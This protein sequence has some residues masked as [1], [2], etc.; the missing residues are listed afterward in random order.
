M[1]LPAAAGNLWAG[2]R[3][4]QGPANSLATATVPPSSVSLTKRPY[5]SLSSRGREQYQP[6]FLDLQEGWWIDLATLHCTMLAFEAEQLLLTV[7]SQDLEAVIPRG[8]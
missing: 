1:L 4:P 6:G 5:P 3:R 2:E 7:R 8:I